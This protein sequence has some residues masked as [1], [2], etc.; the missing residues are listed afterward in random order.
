MVERMVHVTVIGGGLAGLSAAVAAVGQGHRVT[1][2]EARRFAG[3]RAYAFRDPGNQQII[4]NGQ[5]LLM[6]CYQATFD[7]LRTVGSL[8][9]V[10]QQA[11]FAVT[12]RSEQSTAQLRCPSWPAPLHLAAGLWRLA[13]FPRRDWF[14]LIWMLRD[15]RRFNATTYDDFDQL[16]VMQWLTRLGQSARAQKL[17]W[18]PLCLA[19]L[20][21]TPE[22]ASVAPLLAILQ[23]GVMARNVPQGLAF[24]RVS[25]SELLVDPALHWLAQHGATL[26][27]G[28][29]AQQLELRDQRVIA[30]RTSDGGTLPVDQLI[31]ALPPRELLQLARSSGLAESAP[32]NTLDRWQ[33]API[34]SVHV[35]YDRP[36]VAERMV[37]LLDS[38]FHWAFA[39]DDISG[40]HCIA[41]VASAAREVAAL[42]RAE[43]LAS[44]AREVA[45]FFPS[46]RAATLLH[47]QMTKELHATISLTPGS[48]VLR[49]GPATTLAN[50]ALAGDWTATGLPATIESAVRS[51]GRAVQHLNLPN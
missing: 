24:P 38:P 17:F 11:Q 39:K 51:G 3:G 28:C 35:W 5:H 1:V 40:A 41:L 21:E 13:G 4:D 50:C 9:H 10:E 8:Q 37:G 20:N 48:H 2:L 19:V 42:P 18:E 44:A 7:F 25:L 15:L 14:R 46:A 34:V 45:R 32:W 16:S 6:G 49:W 31:L 36:V 33:T 47:S 26:Q 29:G 23:E 22:R 30:V 12:L 27:H 43:L